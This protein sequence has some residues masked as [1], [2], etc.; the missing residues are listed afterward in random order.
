MLAA[1]IGRTVSLCVRHAVIVAVAMALATGLAGNYVVGHFALNSDTTKLLAPD[2][3][4]R[5][6]EAQF[7]TIFPDRANLILIV[8]DGVTPERTQQAATGLTQALAKR[9]DLFH[10]VSRP[11][12]GPFFQ[13]NGLLFLKPSD[14]RSGLDQMIAA[15]PFLGAL[16]ADPTLR[17]VMDSLSTAL[18]GVT[19]G[20]VTLDRMARPIAE[21]ERVLNQ[22]FTGQRAFL[23]WRKL[24]MGGEPGLRETRQLI[25]AEAVLDFGDLT[26]GGKPSRVI[27][28]T[29]RQ[30][31]FTPETGVRVRLTGP[32]PI[33]DEEFATLAE[34]ADL[35]AAI[36]GGAI[37]IM[38]WF[39][40]HSVRLVACVLATIFAGLAITTALG[41]LFVGA[42]N[43]ISIAFIALF[44]GLGIDFGIQFCVRYRAER[45]AADDLETALV[46]AGAGLGPS[47]TL[48]MLAITAGFLAF[49]PTSYSGVAELGLVA[50]IGMPLTFVLSVTLLPALI[51]LTRP[52]AQTVEA[53]FAGLAPVDRF[54]RERARTVAAIAAAAG[55]VALALL[56]WLEFDFNPLNLRSPKVE[57]MATLR[58]LSR[59]P[60]T[61]PNTMDV[62]VPS[63]PAADALA[64][65]LAALPEVARVVT[66]DTFIPK[67]QPQNLAAIADAGMLLDLTLSPPAVKPPPSDADLVA[68][69]KATA[70]QLRAAAATAKDAAATNARA[71]AASLDR[72]AAGD[73]DVRAQAAGVLT[74]GLTT[75]LDQV[76]NL[77]KASTITLQSLPADVAREWIAPSGA[78]RIKVFPRG[79]PTDNA[80]LK[81]FTAAV[82]AV[83]PQAVG[84]PLS[85]AESGRTI[86]GAF[87]EAG[88]LSL[89]AITIL[90]AFALRSVRDVALSLGPLLLAAALTLGTCVAIGLKLNYANIIAL[91]LLFGIGVA[92]DIYFVMA[93]RSGSRALLQSPLSRA[94]TFSAGTTASGFGALWLSSHPGTA[95]MGELLMISLAW[96]LAIVLFVLPSLFQLSEEIGGRPASS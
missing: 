36:M 13:K 49:L 93:W 16:A 87:V 4:W 41:L 27:R 73:A 63:A 38:L 30:L 64:A 2:L 14:A 86:S 8:I 34:R 19:H 81:R 46:A 18:L 15:Q 69:L 26:P 59:D 61:S 25:E 5:Q 56:P 3:P 44:I 7:Q 83:A 29:A 62:V 95:S 31:G 32:V 52:P 6:R 11:D 12:G 82:L 77:L 37:L 48:A 70:E 35:I 67:D 90:L 74:D 58:D 47:L 92:F 68:S 23:S 50:G 85:I 94:V 9:S 72:L 39:A 53:G 54:L 84:V 22:F 96:I 76:R 42:F 1:A 21:F 88:V 33:A 78:A 55:I 10:A 60:D 51:K 75:L 71:L 65:K 20:Q 57:S 66:I 80:M 45:H 91:P 79:D 17:G 24:T 43:V 40:L 89:I 28:E